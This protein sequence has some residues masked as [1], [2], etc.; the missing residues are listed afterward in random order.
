[1]KNNKIF[2]ARYKFY[3]YI[4][5]LIVFL[6]FFI[7]SIMLI[8]DYGIIAT[9]LHITIILLIILIIMISFS[10]LFLILILTYHTLR[11]EFKDNHLLL[12]YGPFKDKIFYKDIVSWENKD[13]EFNPLSSL[14]MPGIALFNC[15]F[16]NEGKVRM[17]A[18][19]MGSKVLLVYTKKRKY[20]LTPQN[21]EEFVK[22][23]ERRV[24][25]IKE[26]E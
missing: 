8:K 14:R 26:E 11:Y 16:A 12:I 10:I 17:F 6:T 1:M 5:L 13:L 19:S 7:A 24:K 21:E 3:A 23:L 4:S 20:G 25:E 18:T 9:E 22:E 15:Y 2:K